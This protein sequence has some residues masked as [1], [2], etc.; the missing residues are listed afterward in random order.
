M[1]AILYTPTAIGMMVIAS[2]AQEEPEFVQ[3]AI[4]VMPQAVWKSH[5]GAASTL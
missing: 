1:V 5:P 4:T 3:N 2:Q